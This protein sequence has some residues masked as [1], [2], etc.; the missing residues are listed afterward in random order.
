MSSGSLMYTRQLYL[1]TLCVYLN[2]AKRVDLKHLHHKKDM[3]IMDRIEMLVNS[4]MM[5]T[6]QYINVSN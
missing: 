3:K 6:L 4:M 2:S 1:T 5:I